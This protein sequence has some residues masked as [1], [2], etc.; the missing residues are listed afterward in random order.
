MKKIRK[1]SPPAEPLEQMTFEGQWE[2]ACPYCGNL[3]NLRQAEELR[4]TTCGQK[5]EYPEG[6]EKY[7]EQ[8]ND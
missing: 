1:G 8:P 7:H 6:E 2:Y 4:C 3:L 5:I